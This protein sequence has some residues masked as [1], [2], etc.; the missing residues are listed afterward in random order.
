M[1]RFLS[2]LSAIFWTGLGILFLL[3]MEHMAEGLSFTSPDG[4]T[5]LRAIVAG[6][7]ISIGVIV[8]VF[9]LNR[10][11]LLG[12]FVSACAAS[13]L[14]LVR[15]FGMVTDNA[16]T[17]SQVRDLIPEILGFIVVIAIVPRLRS[18][19]HRLKQETGSHS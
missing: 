13:G 7:H 1:I 14:A 8:A 18:E 15:L 2:W 3:R 6:L 5:G 19:L 10:L 9:S 17:P 11:Y 12:V 4:L 16:F